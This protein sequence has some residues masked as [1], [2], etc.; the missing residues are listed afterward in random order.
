[1]TTLGFER[2]GA[3]EMAAGLEQAVEGLVG[4]LAGRELDDETRLALTYRLVE[5]R[6]FGLLGSR[7]L[8]RSRRGRRAGSRALGHQAALVARDAAA[9]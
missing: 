3:I 6:L 8:G 2:A 5:A 7:A 4:G 9:G 1:M